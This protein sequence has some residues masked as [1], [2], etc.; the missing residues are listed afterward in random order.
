MVLV[1]LISLKIFAINEDSDGD[2]F[3]C[4]ENL[5]L[6]DNLENLIK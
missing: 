1:V 6:I 3:I 4:K 5:D 2:F